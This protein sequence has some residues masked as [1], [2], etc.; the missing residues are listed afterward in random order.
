[1][2]T[3]A[4]IRSLVIARRNSIPADERIARSEKACEELVQYLGRTVAPGARIAVYH[5]LGSEVDVSSFA[6]S[7]R[8]HGW[9]CAFPVMVRNDN[10]AKARMTF[11]DVPLDGTRRAFFD[12]PAR[13]VT[14]DDPSLAGCT[15]CDPRE[16]DAVVVPMVA[17]DAGNMR[18]GYGG[19]NYDRFLRE[20]RSDAVVCGIAFREQEVE[21]VPTEPHDLALP[22]IIVA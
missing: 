7:A 21:A 10:D 18:L 5:A 20:L 12:K 9:T 17:F 6:K 14:P 15:P 11:W 4:E 3:K 2:N 22:K 1:M 16:I 8:L 19:G 13:T